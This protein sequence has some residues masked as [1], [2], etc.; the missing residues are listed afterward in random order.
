MGSTACRGAA[1]VTSLHSSTTSWVTS[2][3][4]L[5][6][7]SDWRIPPGTL[8]GIRGFADQVSV[9]A[10]SAVTICVSTRDATFHVEAYRLGYY[11]GLGARLVWTSPEVTGSR[12][13][14]PT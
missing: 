7:T 5:P 9:Q 11:Q 10:G 12:Q 4:Q 1:C 8:K 13:H 14:R 3:N 2:E 6:G